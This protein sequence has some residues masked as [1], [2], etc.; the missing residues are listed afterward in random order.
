MDT[1]LLEGEREKKVESVSHHLEKA[2]QREKRRDGG[3]E[4]RRH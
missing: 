2:R 4:G 1:S 3:T